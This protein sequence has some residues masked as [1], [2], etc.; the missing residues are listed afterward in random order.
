VGGQ[1]RQIKKKSNKE[2]QE[3]KKQ[4]EELLQT[5]VRATRQQLSFSDHQGEGGYTHEGEV[6]DLDDPGL[7][8][9]EQLMDYS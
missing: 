9:Q 1:G 7:M 2:I 5:L 4:R 8:Q 6:G 3:M